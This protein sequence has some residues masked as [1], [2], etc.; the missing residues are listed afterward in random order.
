MRSSLSTPTLR[1]GSEIILDDLTKQPSWMYNHQPHNSAL[2]SPSQEENDFMFSTI[3]TTPSTP[4]T[5]SYHHHRSVHSSRDGSAL[6][7]HAMHTI[8]DVGTGGSSRQSRQPFE[9]TTRLTSSERWNL[10]HV[11]DREDLRSRR[12]IS[13]KKLNTAGHHVMYGGISRLT[14]NPPPSAVPVTAGA[15]SSSYSSSIVTITTDGPRID[16]SNDIYGIK[17]ATSG[18]ISVPSIQ[19]KLPEEWIA[20]TSKLNSQTFFYNVRTKQTQWSRPFRLAYPAKP[21]PPPP[22]KPICTHDECKALSFC[23]II[24]PHLPTEEDLLYRNMEHDIISMDFAT[25]LMRYGPKVLLYK[26]LMGSVIRCYETWQKFTIQS[27]INRNALQYISSTKIQAQYR[28]LLVLKQMKERIRE[29][30]KRLK[31]ADFID[32]RMN[33]KEMIENMSDTTRDWYLPFTGNYL[34]RVIGNSKKKLKSKKCLEE[35]CNQPA[36]MT[37]KNGFCVQCNYDK[38]F[39]EKAAMRRIMAGMNM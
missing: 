31:C 39:P 8:E 29:Y 23:S 30:K 34:Q 27:K 26:I 4:L 10:E 1:G 7:Q 2:P 25:A 38:R 18:V 13:S 36:I 19:K 24:G 28:R 16:Y 6:Y 9:H 20:V 32:I 37:Q 17:N 11:V 14:T 15:G 22:P 5:N 3:S 12:G 21:P 35:I 33:I